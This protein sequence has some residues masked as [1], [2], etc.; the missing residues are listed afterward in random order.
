MNITP[1]LYDSSNYLQQRD[2]KRLIQ[3]IVND[4]GNK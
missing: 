2:G 1:E 3:R 4:L